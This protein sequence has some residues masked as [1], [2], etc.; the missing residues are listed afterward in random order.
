MANSN[1]KRRGRPVGV[2][3]RLTIEREAAELVALKER[4]RGAKLRKLSKDYLADM[5]PQT[6][7]IVQS[8]YRAA[9]VKTPDDPEFGADDYEKWRR[10]KEWAAFF[11]DICDRHAA[12]ESPK[13]KS[14]EVPV[15]ADDGTLIEGT[16]KQMETIVDPVSAAKAYQQL[17]KASR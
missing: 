4:A 3:N 8:F 14:I 11:A 1:P 13:F 12:Y 10:L 6:E 15:S 5:I 16:A 2:R 17:V 7:E 9:S